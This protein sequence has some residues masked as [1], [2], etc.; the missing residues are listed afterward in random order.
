MTMP[1]YP[2]R[3]NAQASA[4]P[5]AL[6]FPLPVPP[7]TSVCSKL[8]PMVQLSAGLAESRSSGTSNRQQP[9]QATPRLPEFDFLRSNMFMRFL[10]ENAKGVSAIRRTRP[11]ISP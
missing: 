1:P 11:L 3:K 7:S 2:A 4:L 6:V 8:S 5:L 9:E 10:R